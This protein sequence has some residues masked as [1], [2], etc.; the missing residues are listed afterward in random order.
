MNK[1]LTLSVN[2]ELIDAVK[3]QARSMNLS[4][5]SLVTDC[6]QEFINKNSKKKKRKR[7]SPLIEKLS[8]ILDLDHPNIK[9]DDYAQYLLNKDHPLRK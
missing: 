3:E 2:E 7:F 6:F 4:L 9:N 8:G 1:K 5:S